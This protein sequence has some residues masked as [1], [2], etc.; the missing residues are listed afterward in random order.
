MVHDV[1]KAPPAAQVSA[2]VAL[3]DRGWS[4]PIRPWWLE[5]APAMTDAK[6]LATANGADDPP[7]TVQ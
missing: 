5:S 1:V 7:A 3:L 6:L 2:A 4:R